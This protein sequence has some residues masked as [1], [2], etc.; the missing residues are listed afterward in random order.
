MDGS[1]PDFHEGGA[2]L[3]HRV[4]SAVRASNML[5]QLTASRGAAAKIPAEA[6]KLHLRSL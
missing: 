4:I 5:A 2:E 6:G 3:S 1:V